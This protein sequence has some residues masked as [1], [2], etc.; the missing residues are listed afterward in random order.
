MA[1]YAVVGNL[2]A[3]STT[4]HSAIGILSAA[5]ATRRVKVFDI[6][7]GPGAAPSSTDTFI[8]WYMFRTTGATAGTNTAVTPQPA[9][10]ADAA[11]VSTSAQNYTAEGTVIAATSVFSILL[12]QRAPYRWQTYLGSGGELVSTQAASNGF[13]LQATGGSGGY[14]G[15]AGG[16]VYFQEQ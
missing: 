16:T 3:V 2:A 6:N 11:A 5:S 13:M 15:S 10:P 7:I 14:T 9:D 8:N 4:P 1:V 12:N